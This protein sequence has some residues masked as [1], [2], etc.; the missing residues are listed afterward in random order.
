MSRQPLPYAAKHAPWTI[1]QQVF[2]LRPNHAAVIG[3]CLGTWPEVE[4]Q[5]ARMLALL[6]RADTDAAVAVYLTL[7]R[8][9]A[10][11][12]AIYAAAIHLEAE[13]T[14]ILKALMVVVD[15]AEGERNS[16][17]HGQYFCT[18]VLPESILWINMTDGVTIQTRLLRELKSLDFTTTPEQRK[19]FMAKVYHYTI[20]SLYSIRDQI[21]EAEHAIYLFNQY[22]MCI[23][24]FKLSET[25]EQIYDRIRR[26][27]PM[28]RAIRHLLELADRKAQK[29]PVWQYQQSYEFGSQSG[30]LRLEANEWVEIRKPSL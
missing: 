15:A 20:K 29:S 16:L 18:D 27:A 2:V 13:A 7:R 12:E 10:R 23:Q 6:L 9:T 22:L 3:Q 8:S 26:L 4:M 11:K 1:G 30:R 24:G 28:A 25:R 14:A 19:D 17:A 5:M 21:F